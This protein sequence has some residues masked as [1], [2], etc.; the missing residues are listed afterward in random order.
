MKSEQFERKIED[1][2]VEGWKV[3]DDGMSALL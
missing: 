1:E 2:K 3:K